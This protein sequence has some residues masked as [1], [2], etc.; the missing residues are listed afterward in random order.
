MARTGNN[1][2]KWSI[3]IQGRIMVLGFCPSPYC[4]LYIH[5]VLFKCHS[6]FKV[7]CRTR[8]RTDRQ[9]GDFML[10]L[11][12]SIKM[13]TRILCKKSSLYSPCWYFWASVKHLF[14][15]HLTISSRYL[16]AITI[17]F[18]IYL[19]LTHEKSRGEDKKTN[20]HAEPTKVKR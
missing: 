5:Q 4:H 17:V 2:E 15:K 11:L 6:S 1:Y 20:E 10:P 19:A 14:L 8:Y 18:T 3:N 13:Y 12:G 7:I 16:H 9:S